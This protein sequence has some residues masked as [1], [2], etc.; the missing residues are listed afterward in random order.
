MAR[1]EKGTLSRLLTDDSGWQL[2]M[3]ELLAGFCHP[4]S[5]PL[6]FEGWRR[7]LVMDGLIGGQAWN[8][9][10]KPS[11][12]V[13]NRFDC[14]RRAGRHGRR[15][16]RDTPRLDVCKETAKGLD[17]CGGGCIWPHR[18]VSQVAGARL[19]RPACLSRPVPRRALALVA[20]PPHN[21]CTPSNL[22]QRSPWTSQRSQ[23]RGGCRDAPRSIVVCL[24]LVR[25]PPHECKVLPRTDYHVPSSSST[26][27]PRPRHIRHIL[28]TTPSE[29][30]L[31]HR[32]SSSA[33]H[34]I[35]S[36]QRVR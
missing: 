7:R 26:V 29:L 36:M 22:P 25:R 4:Q 31:P 16:R 13:R 11:Y 33:F 19:N 20:A 10:R 12:S 27:K 1:E 35:E 24:D 9:A 15:S 23:P 30:A 28:H 17:V 14:S 21:F 6:F 3:H 18:A 34:S 8:V 32:S 5:P 2:F